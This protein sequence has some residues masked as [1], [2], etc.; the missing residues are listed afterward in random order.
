MLIAAAAGAAAAQLNCGTTPVSIPEPF[1]SSG[2]WAAAFNAGGFT[3]SLVMSFAPTG[4]LMAISDARSTNGGIPGSFSFDIPYCVTGVSVS[5]NGLR[6][7]ISSST[8]PV[9]GR[10]AQQCITFEIGSG[11]SSATTLV[12]AQVLDSQTCVADAPLPLSD[13]TMDIVTY[14]KTAAPSIPAGGAN[15]VEST[16]LAASAVAVAAVAAAALLAGR[17]E[18]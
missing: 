7:N 18:E 5:A 8:T 12:S 2:P 14:T 16:T 6:A 11:G 9:M 17:R 13:P 10:K 15:G 3:G 1:V 4:Y